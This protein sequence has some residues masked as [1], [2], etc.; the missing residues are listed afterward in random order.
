MGYRRMIC[1]YPG[2]LAHARL[3]WGQL[4]EEGTRP[5]FDFEES[6]VMRN[7]SFRPYLAR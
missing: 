2:M 4:R 1:F 3:I 7:F 5:V 6:G